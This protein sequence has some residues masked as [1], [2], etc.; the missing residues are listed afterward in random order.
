MAATEQDI[1]ASTG[2]SAPAPQGPTSPEPS[3]LCPQQRQTCGPGCGRGWGELQQGIRSPL[4]LS[5]L[6]C[7]LL[8]NGDRKLQL[9]NLPTCS[10]R[11]S[12]RVRGGVSWEGTDL[13]IPS[14]EPRQ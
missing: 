13:S 2:K 5:C 11:T 7:P 10:P 12:R 6:H 14:Q 8:G 3:N 4:P 1:R 9:T